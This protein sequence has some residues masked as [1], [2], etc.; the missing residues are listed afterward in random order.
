[1]E[2]L[3]RKSGENLSRRHRKS[4]SP[5]LVSLDMYISDLDPWVLTQSTSCTMLV[6][7]GY[8]VFLAL[9]VALAPSTSCTMLA[10]ETAH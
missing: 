4:L 8:M 3:T 6:Q 1:M 9:Q 7:V 2:I 5:W 10:R